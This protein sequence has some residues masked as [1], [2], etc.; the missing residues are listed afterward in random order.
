MCKQKR[1]A[2][3][4][5]SLADAT[6]A[7][8]GAGIMGGLLVER[9]I[10]AGGVKPGNVIAC[11]P[12]EGRL[13]ELAA[14][15]GIETHTDNTAAP[16]ADVILLA[17]PPPAVEPVRELESERQC[18]RDVMQCSGQVEIGCAVGLGGGTP[19]GP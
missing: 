9:L 6:I 17:V 19:R 7:T 10:E 8:A 4:S 2:A 1:E 12:D 3:M 11:D 5:T 14:R 18:A 15:L 13:N 16:G